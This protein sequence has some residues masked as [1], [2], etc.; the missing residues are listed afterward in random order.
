MN[1]TREK[2]LPHMQEAVNRQTVKTAQVLNVQRTKTVSVTTVLSLISSTSWKVS[3][4]LSYWQFEGFPDGLPLLPIYSLAQREIKNRG[5]DS[6]WYFYRTKCRG[7]FKYTK[8]SISYDST[9]VVHLYN[10]TIHINHRVVI[11][12]K[13]VCSVFLP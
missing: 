5:G 13:N 4:K 1:A 2:C 11:C 3:M 9:F 7:P 10:R 6:R 8:F 12:A